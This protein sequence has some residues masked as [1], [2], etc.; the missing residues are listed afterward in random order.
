MK[1]FS[2]LSFGEEAAEEEMAAAK[3]RPLKGKSVYHFSE[4]P[5][6][7]KELE[8]QEKVLYFPVIYII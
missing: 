1:N 5:A 2:L 8:E 3:A 6:I 7:K 4:D